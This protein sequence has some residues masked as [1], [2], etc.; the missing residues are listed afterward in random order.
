MTD[1]D[2]VAVNPSPACSPVLR[3]RRPHGRL[4][5]RPCGTGGICGPTQLAATRGRKSASCF[6]AGLFG[7]DTATPPV[8]AHP[9]LTGA[10]QHRF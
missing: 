9:A 1:R 8:T 3:S 7:V 6:S 5:L 10:I 2:P 4:P